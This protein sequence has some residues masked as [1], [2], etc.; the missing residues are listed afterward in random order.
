MGVYVGVGEVAPRSGYAVGDLAAA[1]Y[2][3]SLVGPLVAAYTAFRFS[4]FERFVRSLVPV[5]LGTVVVLRAWWP[6]VLGAPMSSVLA[7]VLAAGA[8][9]R[10][11]V[12]WQIV[13]LVFATVL[14]CACLGL[15]LARAL[16]VALAVPAAAAIA[17][18]WLVFPGAG[19]GVLLRN[20][21]AGFVVCCTSAT[22]PSP[23]MLGG[24]AVVAVVV[25]LGVMGLWLFPAWPSVGRP[26][27]AAA[28]V[29]VCA[30]AFVGGSVLVESSSTGPTFQ[31]IERRTTAKACSDRSDVAVCVWPENASRVGTVARQVVAV[32]T[33]FERA[34]FDRITAVEEDPG[35]RSIG[36]VEFSVH[37]WMSTADVKYSVVAGYTRA[38]LAC[39]T[40]DVD[41]E[42][43]PLEVTAAGLVGG[44]PRAELTRR[45]GADTVAEASRAVGSIAA[46][47]TWYE[48]ELVADGSC[49]GDR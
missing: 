49:G 44:V 14:A 42:P 15:G 19:D 4:G 16:P 26:A 2:Q 9:P 40:G 3:L 11:A 8:V 20:L 46:A 33:R 35:P 32:N 12:S 1:S 47:R 29:V 10:D 27:A 25:T 5:R 43:S 37:R 31:A 30:A 24:S 21:N 28:L 22:V 13:G 45:F 7:L 36:T 18:W 41:A 17:Y 23:A 38:H 39:R 48:R 34:G 6:V